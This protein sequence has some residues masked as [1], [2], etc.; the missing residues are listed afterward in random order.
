MSKNHAN[1]SHWET[2]RELFKGDI[3]IIGGGLVGQSIGIAIQ[4]QKKELKQKPLKICI[5]E[6]L[7]MGQSGASTRN[8]GFACFGSPT[9]ILDD[10]SREEENQTVNRIS[11]FV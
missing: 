11:N 6:K 2:N 3:L 7:P 10:L 4:K 1:F 8:A 5:V 9:E